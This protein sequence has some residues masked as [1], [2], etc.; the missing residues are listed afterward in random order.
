MYSPVLL[1]ALLSHGFF[2]NTSA[3][4]IP[5]F[6]YEWE[7][8]NCS[9]IEKIRVGHRANRSRYKIRKLHKL[10]FRFP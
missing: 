9:W 3:S 7:I 5:T 1:K 2:Y 10:Y 8:T 6:F 4:L